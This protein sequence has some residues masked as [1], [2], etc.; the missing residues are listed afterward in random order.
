MAGE[1][2]ARHGSTSLN[3]NRRLLKRKKLFEKER[4]FLNLKNEVFHKDSEG[5]LSKDLSKSERRR[6]RNK[7][8]HSY[9]KDK[10]YTRIITGLG[11]ILFFTVSV[12]LYVNTAQR[13]LSIKENAQNSKTTEKLKEYDY[14]ISS[15]NEWYAKEKYYNAAFQ[16]QLALNIFPNDSIALEKLIQAYDSNCFYDQRNCGKSQELMKSFQIN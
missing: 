3:E 2:F 10:F 5:I 9:S 1:G 13:E 4:S 6:Y 11:L 7:T 14:Y 12:G 15:G 16:Y 8:R